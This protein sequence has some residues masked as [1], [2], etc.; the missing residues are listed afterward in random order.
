MDGFTLLPFALCAQMALIHGQQLVALG[1]LIAGVCETD[2]YIGDSDGDIARI[3]GHDIGVSMFDGGA[4]VSIDG[5]KYIV[6][7][8]SGA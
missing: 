7:K 8:T 3:H 2:V 1:S 4:E 6:P 5:R